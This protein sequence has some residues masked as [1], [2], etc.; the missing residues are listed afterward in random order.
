MD[1]VTQKLI[2][3]KPE[4][5]NNDFYRKCTAYNPEWQNVIYFFYFL[6]VSTSAKIEYHGSFILGQ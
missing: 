3:A 1:Y 5:I 6:G 4:D 2:V